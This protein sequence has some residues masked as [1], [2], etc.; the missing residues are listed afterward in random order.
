MGLRLLGWQPADRLWRYRYDGAGGKWPT[1]WSL[2]TAS[3][4]ACASSMWAPARASCC[5]TSPKPARAWRLWASTSHLT[6]SSTRWRASAR[7]RAGTGGGEA[8]L[9]DDSVD[10]VVSINT[11]H[12]LYNYDTDAAWREIERLAAANILCRGV[13]KRAGESEPDVLAAHC[14][15]L[16][17]PAEWQ[18][19]LDQA[20]YTGD[21]EFITF[22]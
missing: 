16:H 14:R 22:E 12:N 15:A 3:G 10:L 21:H 5:M 17:M 7:G 9:P 13:R 6:R 19:T 1:R 2:P 4:P 20:G 11:L 8:R 18:W